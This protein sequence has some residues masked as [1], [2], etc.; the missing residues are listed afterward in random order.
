MFEDKLYF[1][2]NDRVNGFELWVTDG[3]ENGTLRL[4]D[5]FLVWHLFQTSLQCLTASSISRAI[6]GVNGRNFG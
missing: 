1:A 6:D 2:A 4:K 3:T 5:I